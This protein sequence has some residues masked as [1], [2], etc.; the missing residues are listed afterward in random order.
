MSNPSFSVSVNYNDKRSRKD[1]NY[2][3]HNTD[4]LSLDE[5]KFVYKKNYP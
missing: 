2:R 5:N 3:M 1:W 4:F